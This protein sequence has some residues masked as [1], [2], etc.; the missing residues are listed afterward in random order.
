MTFGNHCLEGKLA[1][2]DPFLDSGVGGEQGHTGAGTC[3]AF[4]PPHGKY[5][6][7]PTPF[8]LNL[9]PTP[10]TLHPTP[11]TLHP[12]PYTLHPTPSTLNTEAGGLPRGRQVDGHAPGAALDHIH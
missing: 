12:T 7:Y 5:S 3:V 2:G 9:H 8:T 4:Q 1:F 10:Y 6:L 11:Y